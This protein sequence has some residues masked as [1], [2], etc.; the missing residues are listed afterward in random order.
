MKRVTLPDG[1]VLEFPANTPQ[2]V[3]DQ[4]QAREAASASP[5][6]AMNQALAKAFAGRDVGQ[7][8]APMRV[9]GGAKT[10]LDRA[11]FGLKGM[12]TDLTPED[13]A[14]LEQGRAFVDQGGTAASV[15]SVGGDIAIGAVPAFRAQRAIQATSRALP[16]ALAVI[17][18]NPVV[19]GAGAGAATAAALT[20]EN[21]GEAAA[22]GAAGGAAG[23]IV[24][25][26]LAGAYGGAKSFIEPF[27]ETGRNRILKRTLERY[28]ADPN[29]VRAAAANPKVNVPGAMPTL[30][31]A[32]MDP[33]I[34]QLQRGAAAKSVDVASELAE[35]N[36]RRVTAYR[37][38]LDDLAG[39]SG[40]RQA[41][42]SARESAAQNLY[43]QAYATRIDPKTLPTQLKA[44]IRNLMQRPSVQ[45]AMQ[46]ARL[47]AAEEG[48]ALTKAGSI[49]GLH[50]VKRAMDDQISAALKAGKT[51]EADA[52]R[53]TQQKLLGTIEQ[54]SPVYGQARNTYAQMSRPIN[55]MDV[56]EA[57]REKLFPALSNFDEN[58][59]RLRPE[60]YAR[61]LQDS[62]ST[63]RQATG[64]NRATL[65]QVMTPQGVQT[66]E[67]IGRDVARNVAAQ[68]LAKVPGSPTAQYLAAGNTL[69]QI[70]GPTGVPEGF[71]DSQLGR[72]VS[73]V[74]GLPL[75]I[76]EEQ[77]QRMLGRALADPQTA[78]R[79]MAT[80]DPRTMIEILRPY[81]TPIASQAMAA[82]NR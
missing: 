15:G 51:Q 53:A 6:S 67:G 74:M 63:V 13:K 69:R 50:Y 46:S 10:A 80:N 49:K 17:S 45:Q 9:L 55:Q 34:A 23:E 31:E 26:G 41:A 56:A 12:F 36:Q 62:T 68:E 25:R 71:L 37:D 73:S 21:R 75:R 32:T 35:A 64:L 3:I 42:D 76:P 24:G 66:L 30:A 59:T 18:G 65:D 16:R 1:T 29:A 22:L 5:N 82:E 70:A 2:A 8:S 47:L 7:M 28:S 14:L 72:V 38:A 58:L 81:L 33:G 4:V 44:E 27:Y 40:A 11:A 19:A 39:T 52:L 61:A 60:N 43:G 77:L 48:Q 20:P 78:S 79:L 54:L 57:M